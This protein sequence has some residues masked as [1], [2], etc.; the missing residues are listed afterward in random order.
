MCVAE[1]FSVVKDITL[2]TAACVTAYVAWTGLEKWQKELK[3]KA[4]FDVARKLAKSVYSLRDTVSNCR[5]PFTAAAE[6]PEGY[7]WVKHTVE[8]EGQA[9]VYI[10]Q[11]RWEPVANAVRCFDASTLEAEAL[12]GKEIKEKVDELRKC[13]HYLQAYIQA[14]ISN[15]YSGGEN[16]K[17]RDF[18]NK[19]EEAV[20]DVIK[21]KNE[22]TQRINNA[23]EGIESVIRPH[24]SR[25]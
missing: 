11:K 21:D 17:N 22:L 15:K 10:Y 18:A 5:S 3:G 24:L 14:F 4:N 23:I 1:V 19:T 12:W 9:W 25:N 13:V 8:E 7:D 2:S 16:F 6:F 20:W